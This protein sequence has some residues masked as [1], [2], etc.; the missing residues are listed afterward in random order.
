MAG[1][2]FHGEK[3]IPV[4]EFTTPDVTASQLAMELGTVVAMEVSFAIDGQHFHES[5]SGREELNPVVEE[6]RLNPS[7]DPDREDPGNDA[8]LDFY[9]AVGREDEELVRSMVADGRPLVKLNSLR[10]SP[11]LLSLWNNNPRILSLLLDAGA[12]GVSGDK[13]SGFAPLHHAA[14]CQGA[15]ECI[16]LLVQYDADLLCRTSRGGYTPLF[17][18]CALGITDNVATLL[19]MALQR[20]PAV[21][22]LPGRAFIESCSTTR[23]HTCL[24]AAVRTGNRELVSLL[25]HCRASVLAA[26]PNG[27]TPVEAAKGRDDM[28]EALLG[29]S[30]RRKR[31][32]Y[33]PLPTAV[34]AGG[35]HRSASSSENIP[36]P[37]A[38]RV[39]P[40]RSLPPRRGGG[41]LGISFRRDGRAGFL[42][43][44][45]IGRVPEA[46]RM[47]RVRSQAQQNMRLMDRNLVVQPMAA[48]ASVRQ[49]EMLL[50]EEGVLKSQRLLETSFD[51]RFL[52]SL[53][54]IIYR[55]SIDPRSSPRMSTIRP[56]LSNSLPCLAATTVP[57]KN[58]KQQQN[59]LEGCQPTPADESSP[60]SSAP[61]GAAAAASNSNRPSS[62]RIPVLFL[63]MLAGICRRLC[64]PEED[65]DP[66]RVEREIFRADSKVSSDT[67]CI[68]L[69]IPGST[70]PGMIGHEGQTVRSLQ[71]DT[72][73]I[74]QF[75]TEPVVGTPNFRRCRITGCWPN[76]GRAVIAV[77]EKLQDLQD[78]GRAGV[79]FPGGW[80]PLTN[81]GRL[82]DN[83][84]AANSPSSSRDIGLP[85]LAVIEPSR[86]LVSPQ[87]AAWLLGKSG[88]KINRL[89]DKYSPAVSINVD[90]VTPEWRVVSVGLSS[91]YS[92]SASLRKAHALLDLLGDLERYPTPAVIGPNASS[93]EA[94][95]FLRHSG[96]KM[97]VLIPP[98][99]FGAVMGRGGERMR[100]LTRAT[101]AAIQK[102]RPSDSP[103]STGDTL[104]ESVIRRTLSSH[105]LIEISGTS[106]QKADAILRVVQIMDRKALDIAGIPDDDRDS[107]SGSPSV[108]SPRSPST[109]VHRGGNNSNGITERLSAFERSVREAQS[110][111]QLI[112]TY[113]TMTNAQ[114]IVFGRALVIATY[115]RSS[116][117]LYLKLSYSSPKPV[118]FFNKP[119]AASQWAASFPT[120]LSIPMI[121][122]MEE[123]PSTCLAHPLPRHHRRPLVVASLLG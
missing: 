22:S 7:V 60:T 77:V 20:A 19:A 89:R 93:V 107:S 25:V 36:S 72:G 121:P 10:A 101:G 67:C 63:L 69:L 45:S 52:T 103:L 5:S 105:R 3:D 104:T 61:I 29:R 13:R 31:S 48:S 82:E 8:L 62:G 23:G 57:E 73:C 95:F 85:S 113:V 9:S 65:F 64:L 100:R 117:L 16:K 79:S 21:S 115:L 112:N 40:S 33:R 71:A 54:E 49:Y 47:R 38:R 76:L 43:P 35:L 59:T 46:A 56:D 34:A 87:E 84:L 2:S 11:L 74:I 68:C 53:A 91:P 50:S 116:F 18:A 30:A 119:D 90:T 78:R 39:L 37:L 108:A 114:N 55:L 28:L 75:V 44:M 24:V 12:D 120:Y 81:P 86:F 66:Q 122:L 15:S 42:N 96:S 123:A 26:D 83:E 99:L 92:R 80:D 4:V 106:K 118:G 58:E 98:E 110:M 88:R 102:V 27:I 109:S 97:K 41:F 111:P 32:P 94:N 51:L 14:M 17:L 6:L 1:I 70:L